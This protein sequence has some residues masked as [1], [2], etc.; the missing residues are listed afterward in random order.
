M[1]MREGYAEGTPSWV[2]LGTTDVGGAKSFYAGLFGWEYRDQE[3]DSVS[4]TMALCNGHVAA[5]IRPVQ[6]K[7]EPFWASYFAVDD[8]DRAAARIEE[9]GGGLMMTP[10]DVMDAG[11]L[12][13]ATDP[14][15]AVFGIW[16]AGEHFGAAIVNE[17]GG[18][19]WNELITEDIDAI[20]PFYEGVFGFVAEKEGDYTMFRVN[21]REVA[22][23]GNKPRPDIPNH[24]NVYFAVESMPAA[25]KTT[26]EGGGTVV[27]EPRE[28]EG[29]GIIARVSDPQGAAFNIIELAMEID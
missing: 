3:L 20:A 2:D 11:R 18:L 23:G 6:G 29:V 8:V 13:I 1:P 12:A 7:G 24:W 19:N 5:G 4:Y 21:G 22:G 26:N 15:G 9:F 14:T 28:A 25:I 16:Q 10:S 17:H 27:R